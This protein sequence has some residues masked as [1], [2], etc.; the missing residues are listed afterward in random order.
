M[1]RELFDRSGGYCEVCGW[2][3]ATDYHHVYGRGKDKHDWRESPGAGL[4]V[5]R[6]CHPVGY[7][8]TRGSTGRDGI[9][10][11]LEQALAGQSP[12]QKWPGLKMNG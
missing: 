12:A 11:K 5:C 10:S 3:T 1:K 4:A 9:E 2:A 8:H 7:V 6:A